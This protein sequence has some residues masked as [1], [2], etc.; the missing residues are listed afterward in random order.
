MTLDLSR[1]IDTCAGA[2]VLVI[3]DAMLDVYLEGNIGR[4]C[5]EAP[6]PVVEVTGRRQVPGGAANTAV[7]ARVLGAQVEFLAVVGDDDAGTALL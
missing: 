3:G 4:L 1:L 2:K 5:R 6:L 7:N